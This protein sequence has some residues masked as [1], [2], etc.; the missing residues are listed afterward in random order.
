MHLTIKDVAKLLSV[1][2]GIV[3]DLHKKGKL[4]AYNMNG[5]LW[6][7][8]LEIEEWVMG[9]E[10]ESPTSTIK[11]NQKKSPNKKGL[12]Q[13]GLYRAIFRGGVH[14]TIPGANKEEIIAFTMKAVADK[15]ELDANIV[16]DLLLDREKLA[17]TALNH[18]IAI[19]HTREIILEKSCDFILVVYPKHPIKFGA[20]DGEPVHTLFFLFASDNKRHLHLLA[21]IAHLSHN[22]KIRDFLK[23]KPTLPDLLETIKKWEQSVQA[24]AEL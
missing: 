15:L 18:G 4:Q 19:P 16:T 5:S 20:L 12:H 23:T 2:E 8:P 24:L 21:K 14:L 1:P 17:P 6:F 3:Y 13:F 10:K 7:D 22:E 11:K 9:Q